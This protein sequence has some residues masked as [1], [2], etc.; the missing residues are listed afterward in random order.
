M[1]AKKKI[2]I[3]NFLAD[4]SLTTIQIIDS[5]GYYENLIKEGI[6]KVSMELG[7]D[8]N[9]DIFD[10]TK[11]SNMTEVL[12][13]FKTYPFL[14]KFRYVIVKGLYKE[15]KKEVELLTEYLEKP[16]STTKHF[17][18]LDD[19]K[20]DLPC[21]F[22]IEDS[23]TKETMED[24]VRQELKNRKIQ[25]D[26]SRIKLLVDKNLTNK[27]LIT[28]E[29]D[30]LQSLSESKKLDGFNLDDLVDDSK[31]E[32]YEQTYNLMNY[33]NKKDLRSCI[34]ELEKTKFTEDIFLE[35]SKIAWRFRVYLKIKILKSKSIDDSE[36]IK[37]ISVSKYQYKYLNLE[38]SKKTLDETIK[39]LKTIKEVDRLLKST[40]INH[41]IL[42]FYLLKRL[43]G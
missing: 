36:I 30:K 41:E 1:N 16:S 34:L 28:K 18:I 32:S 31:R 9:F 43:C 17:F 2:S 12:D 22:Y 21:D 5:T 29:I 6:E 39:S 10:L 13:T 35:I 4:D 11:Q 24:F 3:E 38:S 25:L 14:N 27:L 20:I 26:S 42:S 23:N 15:N 7:Q 40:N 19:D 33:I 37:L 8:T